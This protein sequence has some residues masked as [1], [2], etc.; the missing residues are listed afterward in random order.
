MA[1]LVLAGKFP[2]GSVIRVGR[3]GDE[4]TFEKKGQNEEPTDEKVEQGA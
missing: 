1:E 4:L 2:G 3:K